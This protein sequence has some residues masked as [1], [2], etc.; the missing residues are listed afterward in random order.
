MTLYPTP[1]RL[2][3]LAETKRGEIHRYGDYQ[4]YD[5][6]QYRCTAVMEEMQRAGWVVLADGPDPMAVAASHWYAH[7][8]PWRLTPEGAAVLA[9]ARESAEGRRRD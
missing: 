4:S 2:R 5:Y 1:T 3:R 7:K 8:T 9:R 6:Y